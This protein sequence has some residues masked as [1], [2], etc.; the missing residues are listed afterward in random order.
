MRRLQRVQRRVNRIARRR[1]VRRDLDADR[2]H[3]AAV[4]RSDNDTNRCHLMGYPVCQ[5]P[6]RCCIPRLHTGGRRVRCGVELRLHSQLDRLPDRHARAQPVRSRHQVRAAVRLERRVGVVALVLELERIAVERAARPTA[7][8][9]LVTQRADQHERRPCRN[10]RRERRA[11]GA[12]V[13]V[14]NLDLRA[15]CRHR[16][17]HAQADAARPNI[18]TGDRLAG[19]RDASGR[20]AR[21]VL[22]EADRRI[23]GEASGDAHVESHVGEPRL[24]VLNDRL[25]CPPVG[26]AKQEGD[27]MPY[28]GI[29]AADVPALRSAQDE[30]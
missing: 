3:D 9:D 10:Q 17:H 26:V 8:R 25:R 19:D 24:D 6:R 4:G 27:A 29:G 22:R 1:I 23:D 15:A 16:M 14:L 30:P 2:R 7:R 11:A 13:G 18:G 5:R 12:G 21:E 28:L 20:V